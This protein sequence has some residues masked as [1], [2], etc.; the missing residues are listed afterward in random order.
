MESIAKKNEIKYI[1]V[2]LFYILEIYY[3]FKLLH[4]QIH[5]IIPESISNVN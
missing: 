4:S 3:A 1:F 2:F 5:V